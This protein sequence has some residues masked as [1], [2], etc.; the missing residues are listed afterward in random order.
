VAERPWIRVPGEAGGAADSGGNPRGFKYKA[1]VLVYTRDFGWNWNHVI[2]VK[3]RASH[4][5]TMICE[6]G[7]GKSPR[8]EAF[9][10][11]EF[12]TKDKDDVNED[13]QKLAKE[14]RRARGRIS[15]LL[16][17]LRVKEMHGELLEWIQWKRKPCLC[18][19]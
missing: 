2:V 13:L 16:M 19:L 7:K 14:W 17:R 6:Y 4:S 1:K 12:T 15:N 11:P 9:G 8:L 5:D 3:G 18:H 10:P